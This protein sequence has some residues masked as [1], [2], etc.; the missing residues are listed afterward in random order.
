MLSPPRPVRRRAPTHRDATPTAV[1]R[2]WR[3]PRTGAPD[4]TWGP[5]S[6]SLLGGLQGGGHLRRLLDGLADARIGSAAA[7]VP[8]HRLVDI[9]VG[10]SR[11]RSEQRGGGHDLAGLAVAALDDLEIE[12]RLLDFLADRGGAD[13][14]DGGVVMADAGAH[15]HHPGPPRDS[16]E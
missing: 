11:Y 5:W 15:R 2:L 10:G 12:P 13:G 1:R 14:L 9:G 4:A 6:G 16:I 7:D 8:R 3:H